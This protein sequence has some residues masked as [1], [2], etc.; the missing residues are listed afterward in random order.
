MFHSACVWNWNAS[1][2]CW[3]GVC[4]P[5]SP[6]RM[7]WT[8][9][10]RQAK[11]GRKHDAVTK[12]GEIRILKRDFFVFLICRADNKLKTITAC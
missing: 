2:C 1:G 8:T 12:C 4:L 3:R 7:T 5:W 10:S 9:L 6:T 11:K